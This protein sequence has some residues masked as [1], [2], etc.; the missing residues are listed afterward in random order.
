MIERFLDTDFILLTASSILTTLNPPVGINSV[1][2]SFAENNIG[3]RLSGFSEGSGAVTLQGSTTESFTFPTNGELFS[4]STFTSLSSVNIASGLSNETTVGKIELFLATP[5]GA[6]VEYWQIQGTYKGRISNRRRSSR[7]VAQGFEIETKP[8]LFTTYP[9]P[10]ARVRDYIQAVGRTFAVESI[11]YP[12]DL[13][14]TID[15]Q[16]LELR[17]LVG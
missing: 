17:E 6:P 14:G 9:T 5:A 1:S 2:L 16:E 11:S 7:G 13:L 15:H 8:I 12:A 3:V 10:P 4:L